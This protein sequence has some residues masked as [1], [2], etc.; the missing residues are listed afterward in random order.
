MERPAVDQPTQCGCVLNFI[1][2]PFLSAKAWKLRFNFPPWHRVGETNP[3]NSKGTSYVLWCR[4]ANNPV[5]PT[6][7]NVR[8]RRKIEKS[9]ANY[10]FGAVLRHAPR[11]RIGTRRALLWPSIFRVRHGGH[12]F[13]G[14]LKVMDLQSWSDSFHC[15][16]RQGNQLFP[17]EHF[18]TIFFSSTKK[19][20]IVNALH[21]AEYNSWWHTFF[22]WIVT[23]CAGGR[24]AETNVFR[25]NCFF[26]GRSAAHAQRISVYNFFL[27]TDVF[28]AWRGI[29]CHH[30]TLKNIG[31][32][33]LL[34]FVSHSAHTACLCHVHAS[35]TRSFEINASSPAGLVFVRRPF[36]LISF[37]KERRSIAQISLSHW[38]D[39]PVSA[40]VHL[41]PYAPCY[42]TTGLSKVEP[43][44]FLT[45][46]PCVS[47]DADSSFAI[48]DFF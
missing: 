45:T 22:N 39:V 12:I 11:R 18:R 27:A 37:G 2:V 28:G 41:Q 43:T 19:T 21:E 1:A 40:V 26:N 48:D 20:S 31:I 7:A 42:A 32:I 47:S 35:L 34:C 23:A 30:Q 44:F 24:V 29:V 36:H 38:Y 46:F 25:N 6:I 16:F 8:E 3:L 5:K 14:D 13:S 9:M 10:E 33:V 4:W 17:G 15:I